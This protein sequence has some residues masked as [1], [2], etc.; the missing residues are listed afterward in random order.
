MKIIPAILP[1][2]FRAIEGGI[3][4]ILGI[5]DTVQIDFV[6][7]HFAPNKTW[8]FNGNDRE[9][10]DEILRQER[11][12]PTWDCVNYEF[13]VM[14][15]DPLS[16]IDTFIMLGPSKIIFHI[17]SLDE[18]PTVQY[19]ET[20][21]EIVR[22]SISFGIALGVDADPKQILPY[23]DYIDTV[24]CMG[25]AKV[26]FQGQAFDERALEQI[27]AVRALFPEKTISVDGGV[28]AENA[29]KIIDS[30]ATTLVVGSAIFQSNDPHGTIRE[31]RSLW[32][33][34]TQSENSK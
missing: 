23:K 28:T 19:F 5:A 12:L 6:D 30:G 17:E 21:P 3:E 8:W 32:N 15:R 2:T 11:G 22:T 1:Q 9:I 4:K 16:L 24:Q 14:V 34:T 13:D 18:E 33:Q 25:I 26:G 7:G 29:K 31:L 27:K 20:L 10:L